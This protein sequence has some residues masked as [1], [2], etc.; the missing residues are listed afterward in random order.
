MRFKLIS[1][2]VLCREMCAVIAR[3]PHRVDATFLPKGLHDIGC[4]K[5][6]R[7]LQEAV[8]AT[9]PGLYDA[10]LLGY[11]LCNNG[12]HDLRAGATPLVL[13]RGHDC[14]TLFLGSRQRY[15]E[16]FQAHPGAY[17]QTTGW[18]ERGDISGE[19]KAQSIGHL[20]GMD[21]SY[22]DLVKKYGEDNAQYLW[23]TLCDTL[24]NYS[25]LTYINMGLGCDAPFE[26]QAR[27]Q[28]AQRS[29]AFE[30][31]PGNL[32]LLEALVAGNWDAADFLVVPPGNRVVASNDDQIVVAQ[33][34]TEAKRSSG[35][36][37]LPVSGRA[38]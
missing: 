15:W 23:E 36:I 10:I 27:Q 29:W 1:C 24:R 4:A 26:A 32:R 35:E 20:A 13:P 19:L 3:A 6:R 9:E 7:R 31:I 12:V 8:D 14:M 28:A 25:R 33:T 21:Q 5:M 38:S 30:T 17:F 18:M 34:E 11:G 22:A 2:E 37:S 16:Y